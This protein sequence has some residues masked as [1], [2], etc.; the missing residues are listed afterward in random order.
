MRCVRLNLVLVWIYVAMLCGDGNTRRV[1]L[2]LFCFEWLI[3]D[4][5]DEND[6]MALFGVRS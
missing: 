4:E 1:C 2:G 6:G 5:V 3:E